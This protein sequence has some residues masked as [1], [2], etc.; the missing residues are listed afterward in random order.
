MYHCCDSG[1]S[2][3]LSEAE[4]GFLWFYCCSWRRSR[5]CS[6][7][8]WSSIWTLSSSLGLHTPHCSTGIL[9][10]GEKE[11]M[12]FTG[13]V[14]TSVMWCGAF[15]ERGKVQWA[16]ISGFCLQLHQRYSYASAIGFTQWVGS[17]GRRANMGSFLFC[18]EGENRK[19]GFIYFHTSTNRT[20]TSWS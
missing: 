10:W 9:K 19:K 17:T 1:S 18:G 20:R 12:I 15:V 5:Q 14:H 8:T 16:H 11:L 13:F 7:Y 6:Y 2:I 3:L 4:R